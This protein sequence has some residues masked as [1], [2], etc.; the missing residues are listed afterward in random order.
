MKSWVAE[1]EVGWGLTESLAPDA[2][3]PRPA[4]GFSFISVILLGKATFTVRGS[5]LARAGSS[6]RPHL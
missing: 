3:L 6:T 1:R 2:R 4:P 5:D